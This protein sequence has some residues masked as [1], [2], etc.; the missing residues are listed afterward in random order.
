MEDDGLPKR[1]P[2]YLIA[3]TA[4][5][6]AILLMVPGGAVSYTKAESSI[7]ETNAY[8]VVAQDEPE[9]LNQLMIE[10]FRA[11]PIVEQIPIYDAETE[12]LLYAIG[13]CESGG[14]QFNPDGTI[15]KNPNSSATGK[16][17]LMASIWRPIA[18]EMGINIDTEAGN[19]K[20]AYYILSEAQGLQ[21]WEA[22]RACL[23][24]YNIFI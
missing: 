2:P 15:V 18:E 3:A 9:S 23:I 21:A 16:Y 14:S 24:K 8:L 10:E 22:S 19:K 1:W 11:D 12:R 20:M 4:F 5:I 17:Q 7:A 6:I 13:M